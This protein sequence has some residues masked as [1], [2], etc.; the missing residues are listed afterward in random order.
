[1]LF[2]EPTRGVAILNL[3]GEELLVHSESS[4]VL[5]CANTTNPIVAAQST[6]STCKISEL[7]T[8]GTIPIRYGF[9]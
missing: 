3:C 5:I 1:M 9:I 4:A 7:R 2:E 6:F 8:I